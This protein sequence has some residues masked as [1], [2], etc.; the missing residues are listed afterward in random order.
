MRKL[1]L[2]IIFLGTGF[3]FAQTN[4]IITAVIDGPLSGGTPKAVELYALDDISDLSRYGLE[5]ANN[6]NGSSGTIESSFPAIPVK[7]GDYIYITTAA[8]T[9]SFVD[10]FGFYPNIRDEG[11]ALFINGDD[12][13]ILYQDGNPVDIFGDPNTDGSGEA[14]EYLDGWAY[15]NSTTGPDATF[16]INNWSFSGPNALD[17][18]TSN[19]TAATPVPIG[20][21]S[22]I[23]VDG[24]ASAIYLPALCLQT[25]TTG[26]GNNND[27]T[28]TTSSGS[29]LDGAHA[30]IDG[31]FLYLMLTGNMETNF[32]KLDIFID[33]VPGGQNTLSGDNPDVDFNGLN[34]MGNDGS[35]NG[36]TFDP[37]FESDYFY[38]ITNGF[39]NNVYEQF[40]STAQTIGMAGSGSFIGG[41][42]GRTRVLNNGALL[43]MNNSNI[44]GVSDINVGDP[45]AVTTGIELAIP[46]SELG[47]P[48]G[49]IKITAFV[50][51]SSHDFVSNQVLCGLD[52][53]V[54]NL[55]ESRNVDF[56]TQNGEQFFTLCAGV[57]G[58][59]VSTESGS[60]REVVCVGD[61]IADFISFDSATTAAANYT[62][63]VTD[64]NGVILAVPGTD[65]IDFEGA[66][67]GI[68]WVWGL[69]YLGNIT[70]QVGDTASQVAL[71]DS[72]FDLSNNF[73]VIARDSAEAGMVLTETGSD[74]AYVCYND[75]NSGIIAFDS[76][77]A[78]NLNFAYVITDPNTTILGINTTGVIDFSGAGN[79]VC[80]VWG[81]SYTGEVLVNVGD[82]VSNAGALTD[83]CFDLSDTFVRV[84]R[85]S[86]SGGNI[87]LASDTIFIDLDDSLSN[88]VSFDSLNVVGSNFTYVVTDTAT[89]IL[90]LPPGDMVDFSG[91]GPGI[92]YVWGLSF[93]G[94]VLVGLGDTAATS[95]ITDGCFDL[96]DDFAVVVRTGTGVNV[97]PNLFGELKLYPVP[98]NQQLNVSF[99]N[100]RL[101]RA[102]TS[103]KI[104]DYSGALI[105]EES[106]TTDN[107]KLNVSSLAKGI[108]L[109]QVQ[110]GDAISTKRFIKE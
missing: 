105:L 107:K 30:V 59:T 56:G 26:F 15:R 11:S 29:E 67:S 18:E 41:G 51:S 106:T 31:G 61:N 33:C 39:N 25:N 23:T 54:T 3:L 34:R 49:E 48:I 22:Q 20:T 96:S 90:G 53:G 75:P 27:T 21:Y 99:E 6:G 89:K 97:E 85:D 71:T 77:G 69:S 55:G 24:E 58:G 98:A 13:L 32:N 35:G 103:I 42:P 64:N 87:A 62:Y 60:F 100:A 81:L 38:T 12:A 4:L 8:G 92:C 52:S 1:L 28:P 10:F 63:V 102:S 82:T 78:S 74:T 108:Y 65:S 40:A 68:C 83:G 50:N 5:A 109:V 44:A 79:G 72:C 94:N 84:F 47:N 104:F 17:N 7:R 46:L 2:T 19:S 9:Q 95:M 37:G 88:V 93:S 80:W 14:W 73:V 66:G 43:G 101:S 91:A 45:S 16:D 86:L 36:L 76:V 70:A 57:D 110:N